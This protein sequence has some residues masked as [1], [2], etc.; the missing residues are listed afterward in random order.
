M[1]EFWLQREKGFVAFVILRDLRVYPRVGGDA[2]YGNLSLSLRIG[3]SKNRH[4][5]QAIA[6]AGAVA[7]T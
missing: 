5:S 7:S 1:N 3:A 2:Q 4:E 6:N